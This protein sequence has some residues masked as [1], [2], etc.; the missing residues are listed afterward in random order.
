VQSLSTSPNSRQRTTVL[1]QMFQIATRN[2]SWIM[3]H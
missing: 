1:T 2:V 3:D